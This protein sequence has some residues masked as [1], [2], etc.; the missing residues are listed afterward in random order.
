M[1]NFI[2]IYQWIQDILSPSNQ[3][4]QDLSQCHQDLS[5]QHQEQDLA[6]HHQELSQHQPRPITVPSPLEEVD[7]VLTDSKVEVNLIIQ[8]YSVK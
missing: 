7:M 5:Q 8:P 6:Q 2:I 3:R 4:H 1:L